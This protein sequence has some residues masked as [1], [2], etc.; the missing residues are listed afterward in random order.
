MISL[1]DVSLRAGGFVLRDI[2]LDVAAGEYVVVMGRTGSGKTT[3]LET[4]CGLRPVDSGRILIDGRDVTSSRP[5]ERGIG[6]VPQDGALFPTMTVRE[7]LEFPLQLRKWKSSERVDRVEEVARLLGITHLLDRHPH[8]LSGGEIQRVAFGRA[9]SFRPALLCLDEPFSA[10]DVETRREM[11]ELIR[12]IRTTHS[13]SA[14]HVT[15]DPNEAERLGDRTL[16]LDTGGMSSARP[17]L[18]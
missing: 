6:Y 4:I 11:L 16:V 10:L 8:G 17:R 7:Q 1:R 14:V 3:L 5:G 18:T 9:L 15:H 13:V 12:S 2:S